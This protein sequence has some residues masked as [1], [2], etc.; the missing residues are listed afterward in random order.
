ML[1]IKE[2]LYGRP[3]INVQN[4]D[5]TDQN[6]DHQQGKNERQVKEYLIANPTPASFSDVPFHGW[7]YCI[8]LDSIHHPFKDC[9]VSLDQT[10]TYLLYLGKTENAG[11]AD[12]PH[13]S[14]SF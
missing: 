6:R 14:I 11:K 7:Q 8:W 1:E 3:G 4:N 12:L 9:L 10:K 13:I 5:Q 2:S